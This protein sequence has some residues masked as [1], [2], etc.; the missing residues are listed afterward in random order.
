VKALRSESKAPAI[1]RSESP[2][3]PSPDAFA[4]LS[5]WLQATI[6]LGQNSLANRESVASM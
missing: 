4:K 6:G 1:A 2:L 3:R 5:I